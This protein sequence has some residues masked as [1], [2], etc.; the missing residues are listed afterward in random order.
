LSRTIRPTDNLGIPNTL[1]TLADLYR[2]EH[3]FAD[4]KPLYDQLLAQEEKNRSLNN[5][6]LTPLLS[7]YAEV[8]RGLHDDA[9]AAAVQARIRAL[10]QNAPPRSA[11]K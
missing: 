3:K 9:G 8:L 5:P 11:P 4:A 10:Q 6:G 1:R 2:E 7:S